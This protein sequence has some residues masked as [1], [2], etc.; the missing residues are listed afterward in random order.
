MNEPLVHQGR[1]LDC[2]A[3]TVYRIQPEIT[4]VFFGIRRIARYYILEQGKT[5]ILFL[6]IQ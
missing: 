1:L 2:F 5:Q 3:D 4:T 6:N